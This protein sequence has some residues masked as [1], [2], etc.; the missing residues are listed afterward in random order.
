MVE[1]ADTMLDFVGNGAKEVVL[2]L[3][4][5]DFF[6]AERLYLLHDYSQQSGGGGIYLLKE[7]EGKSLNQ[8][9]WLC[10]VTEFVFGKLP[11]IIYFKKV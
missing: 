6:Q 8:E 7:Y 1:G 2:A 5:Q 9:M 3:S 10:E 11:K 4:E